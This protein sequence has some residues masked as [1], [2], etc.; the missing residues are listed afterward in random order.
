MSSGLLS[1]EFYTPWSLGLWPIFL[2]LKLLEG[3][4]FFFLFKKL[5]FVN[6]CFLEVLVIKARA[7]YILGKNFTSQSLLVY[8]YTK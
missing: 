7:L 5:V 4:N 6:I 2:F 3:L 1:A 8:N